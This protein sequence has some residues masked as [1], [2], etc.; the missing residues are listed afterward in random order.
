MDT[1]LCNLCQSQ[2][3]HYTKF[4]FTCGATVTPRSV[5]HQSIAPETLPAS[6]SEH[7]PVE[8]PQTDTGWLS[9]IKRLWMF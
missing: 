9:S 7:K 2:N 6:V 4:C 5:I 3:P 1:I 8:K